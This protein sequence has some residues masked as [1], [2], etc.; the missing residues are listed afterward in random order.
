M[1]EEMH[2]I[3]FRPYPK[4]L[5][6]MAILFYKSLGTYPLENPE[7]EKAK[8]FISVEINDYIPKAVVNKTILKKKTGNVTIVSFD[9]G[10]A[11]AEKTSPFDTFI[12]VIDGKAEV[13]I[14]GKSNILDTGHAIIIPAHSPN[15]IKA[16]VRF[17]MIATIIKS[18]FEEVGL[19]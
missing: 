13:V 7:L 10:E 5:T 4:E 16:N 12:Q 6:K 19:G 2:R 3:R 11:L 8:V 9:S 15:T 14:D 17:K 18:G 1:P